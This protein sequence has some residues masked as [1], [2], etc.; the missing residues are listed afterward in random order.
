VKSLPVFA[1]AFVVWSIVAFTVGYQVRDGRAD[2]A[3]AVTATAQETAR[4]DQAVEARVNDHANEQGAAKGEAKRVDKKAAS[5]V[6]FK[7]IERTVYRYVQANPDPGGC[8]LDGDGLR[9]WREANAG[10]PAH[11][12]PEHSGGAAGGAR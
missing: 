9:A 10:R 6:N 8:D 1:I 3:V 2:A 12:E 7:T 5:E 4:A 11:S